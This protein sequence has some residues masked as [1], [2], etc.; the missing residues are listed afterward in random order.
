MFWKKN[1]RVSVQKTVSDSRSKE[2]GP[3]LRDKL[4]PIVESGKYLAAEKD[5]L[6][7]E[8]Q[9]FRSVRESFA[10]LQKQDA[11]VRDA[12]ETF[13]DEF[14]GMS[15]FTGRFTEVVDTMEQTAQETREDIDNVRISSKAVDDKITALRD[16]IKEFQANFKEILS[17]VE[18]ISGVASQT[19]LLALNASIE[20]AR[21]GEHGR[22]FAVVAEQVNVLSADTKSLAATI[23]ESMQKLESSSQ[24]LLSSIEE[25]HS[26]ME[27]SMEYIEK[28]GGVVEHIQGA[29]DKIRGWSAELGELFA[30]CGNKL[31]S[32]TNTIDSS[33]SYYDNVEKDI[34]EMDRN[35]TK[36]S[37]IFEDMSNILGQYP[38]MIE[39]ICQGE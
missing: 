29:S 2:N 35:I 21:A 20:A 13:H 14:E 26:A 34:D 36:K 11:N 8:E 18:Q 5:R 37:L 10:A 3:K 39:R 7:H 30:N 6:Q 9:D 16:T 4:S 15:E 1:D 24:I 33:Q 38:A 25:T 17:A 32:M 31:S 23:G 12:V 22:G 19:N 28:T 27:E